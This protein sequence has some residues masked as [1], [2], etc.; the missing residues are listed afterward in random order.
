MCGR[1][2]AGAIACRGR[3]CRP[4]DVAGGVR[5]G[6]E[7]VVVGVGDV[8]IDVFEGDRCIATFNKEPVTG[9]DN[10]LKRFAAES[11]PPI[12]GEEDA[13]HFA[14]PPVIDMSSA[15]AMIAIFFAE[16]DEE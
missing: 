15:Y 12:G 1:G 6:S 9:D 4:G 3:G 7:R 13:G 11:H 2:L 10:P 5:S 16:P 8:M 14:P